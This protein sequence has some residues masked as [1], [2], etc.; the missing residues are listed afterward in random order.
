MNAKTVTTNF[1]KELDY[2]KVIA[3]IRSSKTNDHMRASCKL[4]DLFYY[5]WHDYNMSSNLSKT[6]NERT[7]AL[8]S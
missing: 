4:M 8:R 1:K 3:V 2:D 5:K 6:F 7:L